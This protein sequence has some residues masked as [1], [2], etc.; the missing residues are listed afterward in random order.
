MTNDQYTGGTGP[1]ILTLG[2][3][4]LGVS[5]PKEGG[6]GSGRL[7]QGVEPKGDQPG[8]GHKGSLGHFTYSGDRYKAGV[9]FPKSEMP[10]NPPMSRATPM[11]NS[12]KI[13]QKMAQTEALDYSPA[14]ENPNHDVIKK[15][16]EA[17]QH[18][19]E[20]QNCVHDVQKKGEDVDPY[21]VCT[22]SLGHQ[23]N[24]KK[25]GVLTPKEADS[26]SNFPA[27]LRGKK[28]A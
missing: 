16:K 7:P 20:W 19:P 23:S 27:Q 13:A 17:G 14:W 18:S 12:D 21:A 6:P 8:G 11:K 15:G 24:L 2:G 28:D 10:H 25:G 1:G 4:L 3:T 26:S 22:T 9:R 5:K